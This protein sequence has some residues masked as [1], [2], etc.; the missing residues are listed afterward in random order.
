MQW[1]RVGETCGETTNVTACKGEVFDESREK[2]RATK[3]ILIGVFMHGTLNHT[4]Y[5]HRYFS[6]NKPEI[7]LIGLAH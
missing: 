7:H 5:H 1:E 4:R 6:Y 2:D 3:P